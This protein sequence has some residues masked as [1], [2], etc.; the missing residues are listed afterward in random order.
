M[1]N[2]EIYS[3]AIKISPVT[4]SYKCKCID[5]R[6]CNNSQMWH[7]KIATLNYYQR[8]NTN[9]NKYIKKNN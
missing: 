8:E 4:Q 2:N 3:F 9:Y 6:H 7:K 5:R 1:N